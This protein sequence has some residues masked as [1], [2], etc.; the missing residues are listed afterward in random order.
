M[1][2]FFNLKQ[3]HIHRPLCWHIV[4]CAL[5]FD[6]VAFFPHP[7]KQAVLSDVDTVLLQ[8]LSQLT[9]QDGCFG[10]FYCTGEQDCWL[11]APQSVLPVPCASLLVF[12]VLLPAASGYRD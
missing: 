8:H 10:R 3:P 12:Q 11:L 6:K 7:C 4:V 9:N 1:V 5:A 2:V